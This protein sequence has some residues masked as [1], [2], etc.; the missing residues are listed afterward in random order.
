MIVLWIFLGLSA[1]IFLL[2]SIPL[3]IYL[4]YDPEAE[5]QYRVKYLFFTL[6]DSE[7]PPREPTQ[8][9]APAVPPK[10]KKKSKSSAAS[11]LLS[12]LGFDEISTAAK[13][14]QS[15]S[16]NGLVATIGSVFAAV[17]DLFGRIFGVVKKGVFRKFDLEIVVGDSDAADAAFS[18]GAV[19]A[20]VYPLLTL[21]E[22]TMKFKK[23]SVNIRCDFTREA[24]TVRFDGQ[25][26]YRPRTFVAFL[27]GLFGRYLKQSLKKEGAK[28]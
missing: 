1:L 8:E 9:A 12:F 10:E 19:C 3:R 22:D 20:A 7:K 15:I 6:A 26:N 17:Q 18:Y 27:L 11:T 13:A 24:S 4:R 5:L 14:R 2:L 23:R 16:E 25:L 28:T 21:L